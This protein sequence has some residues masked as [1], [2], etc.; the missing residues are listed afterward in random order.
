MKWVEI[1]VA[2]SDLWSEKYSRMTAEE[3]DFITRTM[4]VHSGIILK[5]IAP[6]VDMPFVSELWW[7]ENSSDRFDTFQASNL[8]P[9]GY[10]NSLS[11]SH[12]S[13]KTLYRFNGSYF[14]VDS[15]LLRT[16]PGDYITVFRHR[17]S[18]VEKWKEFFRNEILE[19][20]V[21]NGTLQIWC[22][23]YEDRE[24]GTYLTIV[25]HHQTLT[26]AE[27]S[28]QFYQQ[29]V[30]IDLSKT[31]QPFDRLYALAPCRSNVYEVSF[32]VC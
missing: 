25:S 4:G 29:V 27:F 16:R 19:H 2:H 9:G 11:V 22:G 24:Q 15:D 30:N 18:S 13:S 17:T 5:Q 23:T 26:S 31:Y 21:R 28:A 6:R 7:V 10:L 12:I 8:A 1:P 14:G 3:V 20:L 32:S